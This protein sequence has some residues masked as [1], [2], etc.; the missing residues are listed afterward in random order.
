MTNLDWFAQILLAGIFLTAGLGKIFILHYQT[1]AGQSGL[2]A[3][4]LG[5]TRKA[6]Y[7]IAALEIAGALGLLVPINLWRPGILPILSASGLALLMVGAC[8]YRNRR[9][10]F[11]APVVALLLL[12]LMV[13]IGHV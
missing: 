9:H 5:L 4:T 10:E 2:S 1:N 7:A 12:A 8:I 13:V 3:G 6:V 11:T